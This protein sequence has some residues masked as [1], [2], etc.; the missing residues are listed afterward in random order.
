VV[1]PLG[2]AGR[3]SNSRQLT[4]ADV[5]AAGLGDST[6]TASYPTNTDRATLFSAIGWAPVP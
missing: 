2:V 6:Q 5:S 1:P 4:G 3:S